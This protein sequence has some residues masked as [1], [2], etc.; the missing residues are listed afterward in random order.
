MFEN[1]EL[2]R[3]FG[4]KKDGATRAWRKLHNEELNDLYSSPYVFWGDE[5]EKNAIGGACS[6]RTGEE[7]R[8]IQGLGGE[9]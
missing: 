8:H 4:S 3:I 2:R 5:I 1:R 7:D 9:T 6:A